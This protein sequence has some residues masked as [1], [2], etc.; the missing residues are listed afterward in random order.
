MQAQPNTFM[1]HAMLLLLVQLVVFAP[2]LWSGAVLLP[3]A[4][5]AAPPWCASPA[6]S[7]GQDFAGT[8]RA[9]F[10]WPNWFR[11]RE[12]LHGDAT[13]LL[14]NP[15]N[16]CGT[17]FLGTMDTAVAGFTTPLL[18]FFEVPTAAL[19]A[20]ILLGWIASLCARA[21]LARWIQ[22][23]RAVLLGAALFSTT[24]WFIAHQDVFPFVES[25]AWTPLL[26]YGVDVAVR[27][28][29]MAGVLALSA[30]FALSF[31][32]GLPQLTLVACTA[33][34]VQ[35]VVTGWS[36]A[37]ASSARRAVQGLMLATCGVVCG[38]LL[39]LPVL[40]PGLSTSKSSARA[41]IPIED[42][43][44]S[45]MRPAEL[46][47]F[48]VQDFLGAPAELYAAAREGALPSD[49]TEDNF[50]L[51]RMAGLPSHGA[52][53]IERICGAGSIGALFAVLA[54]LHWRDRRVRWS[55]L[56]LIGGLLLA[57][58][59]P[60]LDL[61]LMLP[62]FN[63]GSPRRWVF[64]CVL[65]TVFL[66]TVAFDKCFAAKC[67][68]QLLWAAGMTSGL[69]L[70]LLSAAWLMPNQVAACFDGAAAAQMPAWIVRVCA[71]VAIAI[72][73]ATALALWLHGAR[74]CV[75]LLL[76]LALDGAWLQ[77]TLNP[78]QLDDAPFEAT[79]TTDFLR[80]AAA[81]DCPVPGAPWRIA[82]FRSPSTDLPEALGRPAPLPPN[83]NLLYG[84]AD[85]HGYEGMLQQR[86]EQLLDCVEPGVAVSHHLIREFR[87][88]AAL[89]H[90]ILDL[91]G[92]RL[93][94]S[95]GLLPL[96]RVFAD[97]PALCAVY[98][99]EG[100]QP[101]VQLPAELQVLPDDAAVLAALGSSTWRPEQSA[102]AL[103]TDAATLGW[104]EGVQVGPPP[105][106]LS[107]R[108]ER[109][110]TQVLVHYSNNPAPRPL[111]LAMVHHEEWRVSSA[112]GR[113]L[114]L[115]RGDHALMLTR[116]PAGSGVLRVE[117][118]PRDLVRGTMAAAVGG[119]GLLVL[120]WVLKRKRR[121]KTC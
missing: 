55:L 35:A 15:D 96:P 116:L 47:G 24:P 88:P 95:P 86:Y 108:V 89:S 13:G 107:L 50:P 14:W 12:A 9:V 109:S 56:L 70:V 18:W 119:C 20:A 98:I 54:L 17:P 111:V 93:I 40:L 44:L 83:L 36:V 91:L 48:M 90:P 31:F 66:A 33:A 7:G 76:V 100:A 41:D 113:A 101:L 63:F 10:C 57:M 11:I 79:P 99:N 80:T 38:L 106:D 81:Q 53:H 67:R 5:S 58:A 21:A 69:L 118:S 26:F 43:R 28:R 117:Y 77:H 30:G 32:G 112:D 2:V 78:S 72:A 82:R 22:D 60:L 46:S 61:L 74:L 115:V 25:A 68:G 120:A 62:G 1:R 19:L 94:L 49:V 114:P 23:P 85:I 39:T 34:G 45:A 27:E 64:L 103:P 16:L 65:G 71:P 92:A 3:V 121:A 97:V 59:T 105:A 8:D 104:H 37:R 102:C 52:S 42:L 84:I 29:R 6:A 87:D 73:A 110:A 4:D 75:A 51:A